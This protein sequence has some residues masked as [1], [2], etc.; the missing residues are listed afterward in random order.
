MAGFFGVLLLALFTDLAAEAAPHVH[1]SWDASLETDIIGYNVYY[2]GES[3]NYTNLI[4]AGNVTDVLIDG[5][6]E[7]ATYY[8]AVTAVAATGLES[9]FSNEATY[10]VPLVTPPAAVQLQIAAAPDGTFHLTG[11]GAAGHLYEIQASTDLFSWSAIGSTTAELDGSFQFV[12]NDSV[13]YPARYYRT[14]ETQP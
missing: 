14:S 10:L 7:G 3:G 5:L 2:G 11:A 6:T 9:L 8:F 1:L 12:D 4:S 13:N